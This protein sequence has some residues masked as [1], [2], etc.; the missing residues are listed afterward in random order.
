[1]G[2]ATLDFDGF[3]YSSLPDGEHSPQEGD[4]GEDVENIWPA[5]WNAMHA[6]SCEPRCGNRQPWLFIAVWLEGARPLYGHVSVRAPRASWS[7]NFLGA[8][9]GFW[10]ERRY[11]YPGAHMW[12]AY[13]LVLTHQPMGNSLHVEIKVE[14]MMRMYFFCHGPTLFLSQRAQLSYRSQSC[15]H[16]WCRPMPVWCNRNVVPIKLNVVPIKLSVKYKWKF[17]LKACS[18]I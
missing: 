9:F 6:A 8:L 3:P 7:R 4:E 1:M 18:F 10:I 2:S 11:A 13:V 14:W 16:E 5:K 12:T 15:Y 17:W